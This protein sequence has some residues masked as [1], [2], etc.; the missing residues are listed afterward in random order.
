[1]L[2]HQPAKFGW[3]GYC[4]SGNKLILGY[5]VISQSHIIK[6]PFDFMGRNTSR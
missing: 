5:H 2:S 6:G 1:M 4:G 3:H